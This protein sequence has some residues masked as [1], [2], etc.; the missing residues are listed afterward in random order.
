MEIFFLITE[1]DRPLL[2]RLEDFGE[3]SS[4]SLS[5]NKISLSLIRE[6]LREALEILVLLKMLLVCLVE[7]LGVV[8]EADLLVEMLD[9]RFELQL[10]FVAFC[11]DVLFKNGVLEPNKDGLCDLV[12][13]LAAICGV[14]KVTVVL[15]EAAESYTDLADSF[16]SIE[17]KSTIEYDSKFWLDDLGLNVIVLRADAT[18]V[19]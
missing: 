13:R 3:A 4:S 19:L 6:R 12:A 18:V 8:R 15:L 5:I 16:E 17:T 7:F 14:P 11:D 1:L 9:T 10:P 2:L